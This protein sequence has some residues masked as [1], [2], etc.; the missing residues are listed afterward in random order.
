MRAK[1]NSAF[2]V[3]QALGMYQ[4]LLRRGQTQTLARL[5]VEARLGDLT[6]QQRRQVRQ[7][8]REYQ[9]SAE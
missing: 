7:A 6:P 5:S 2:S 1:S 4:R 3:T 8:L 9:A